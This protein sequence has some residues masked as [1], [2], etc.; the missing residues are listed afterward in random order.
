[1]RLVLLFGSFLISLIAVGQTHPLS[2]QQRSVLFFGVPTVVVG[3][4]VLT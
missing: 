1:M 4:R 2:A 3:V